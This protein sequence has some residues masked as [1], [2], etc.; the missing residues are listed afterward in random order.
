MEGIK[1]NKLKLFSVKGKKTDKDGRKR[2]VSTT[3]YAEDEER[4]TIQLK[5]RGF[6]T[7]SKR[8]RK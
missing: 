1:K 5:A 7:V 6:K 4:A 2:V 8:I 3:R